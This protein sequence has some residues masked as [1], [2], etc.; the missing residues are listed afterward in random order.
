MTL[1]KI[2]KS[3]KPCPFCNSQVE[4]FFHETDYPVT[5]WSMEYIICCR[6]C[7]IEFFENVPGYENFYPEQH[8]KARMKLRRR[9][10]KRGD[11]K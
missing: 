10:N 7:G 5:N 8:E 11:N 4:M 6:K 3:L 1:D 9:W 2:N